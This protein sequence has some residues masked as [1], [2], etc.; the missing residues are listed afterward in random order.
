MSDNV[1]QNLKMAS[2]APLRVLLS[3]RPRILQFGGEALRSANF[4]VV[5]L[6]SSQSAI[7]SLII[8]ISA[9]H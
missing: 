7:A 2:C 6:N 4:F 5:A 9:P 1:A 8:F 3:G